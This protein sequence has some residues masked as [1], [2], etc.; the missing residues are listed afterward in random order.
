MSKQADIPT[1][2]E[3][4]KL[5]NSVKY[6]KPHGLRDWTILHLS[7]YSGL[8]AKEIAS[9]MLQDVYIDGVVQQETYL[10]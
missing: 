10:Q 8:R 4:A 6:D 2:E 7:Y 1:Q 3:L 9:L 5:L